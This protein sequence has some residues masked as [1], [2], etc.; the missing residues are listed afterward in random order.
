MELWLKITKRKYKMAAFLPW[1]L[2]ALGIVTTVSLYLEI[3]FTSRLSIVLFLSSVLVK[4][5]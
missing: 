2:L 5:F 3:N 1:L 4:Y